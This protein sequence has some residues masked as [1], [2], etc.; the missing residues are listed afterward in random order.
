M[1]VCGYAGMSVRVCVCV[2]I[3]ICMYVCMH[4]RAYV[5]MHSI[6]SIPWLYTIRVENIEQIGQI[7]IPS[8]VSIPPIL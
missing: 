4:A 6:P 3:T 8:C 2:C 7:P 1:Y 5:C